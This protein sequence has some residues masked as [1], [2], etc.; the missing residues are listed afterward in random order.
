MLFARNKAYKNILAV[1]FTNKASEEMKTRII[2]DLAEI[3]NNENNS[4]LN[5]II[6][7]LNL[8][9]L[10]VKERAANV[11]K[12]ILH[13]Y[14]FFS[15]STI[16]S[17]FQKIIRNFSREIGLQYNYEVELDTGRVIGVV[18]DNMLE[19][20]EDDIDLKNNIIALVEQNIENSN[21]WDFRNNLKDFLR[22]VI[23]SDFRTYEKKYEEF[24]SDV[25][26]VRIF[27]EEL[28]S[29]EKNFLGIVSN[30]IESIK[31]IISENNLSVADFNGGNSRSIIKRILGTIE[32]INKN[33]FDIENHF[34]DSDNIEKWLTKNNLIKEPLHSLTLR[35]IQK[36]EFLKV[37]ICRHYKN[38]R[39]CSIIK[40]H[41][42]YAALINQTLQYLHIYLNETGKFLI[43][44][45]PAF[46]AEIAN[47]NS[48]SFIYEKIG[49]YYENYLIDEFQDTSKIQ[50]ESFYP[51][52]LESLSSVE[53]DN[54]DII[55]GDV[56]QSIYSWRGGDWKLL[57]K[58]I[59]E[60]FN[61]FVQQIPLNENWR[62]GE[63][64]V[65]FN[66]K[67]FKTASEI[68]KNEINNIT[69]ESYQGV[70]GDLITST[71]YNNIEQSTEKN[72]NSVVN[73]NLYIKDVDKESD[74]KSKSVR[75]MIKQIESLQENG[76]KPGDI[77]ILVRKND[78]GAFVAEEIISY[79]N[80]S[81][82]KRGIIYDVISSEALSVSSNKSVQLIISF[83][84]YLLNE[85][86]R[87]SL[88]ESAYMYY[89]QTR[90][91]FSESFNF[92]KGD[93]IQYFEKE[94]KDLRQNLK[95][96]LLHDIV[97]VVINTFGLNKIS[98]NV[99]FLNSFRD[100][101]HEYEL[102]YPAE[103][104]GFLEYWEE[105]GIKQNLKIPE[106]QNAINII[107]I[108]KA[109]G[110][111]AD[112]VF[113]PFCNWGFYKTSNN[114]IWAKCE[115]VEPFNK[116]PVW[117]V[118]FD[119]KLINSF[120]EEEY[121]LHKFK[122]T[123]ESFNMMYVAF[124]R[125]RKGLYISALD[126]AEGMFNSVEKLL[127]RVF[128]KSEFINDLNFKVV[129]DSDFY[130]LEYEIGSVDNV[131]ATIENV[132]YFDKYP[133]YIPQKQIKVKS[134]FD[135][136]KINIE[137]ESAIH[138]GIVYH[139]IFERIK[140]F[141]DVDLAINDLLLKGNIRSADVAKYKNEIEQIII[142]PYI[143]PWFDNTYNVNNE[144][145]IMTKDG[146]LRRPD[147]IMEIDSEIIIVDYKFGHQENSKYLK[148]AKQYS[149]FLTEM[150]YQNIKSYIWYV[151]SGYLIKVNENG[152][153]FEKIILDR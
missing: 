133:V 47:N 23:D 55:V 120:F 96:K 126:N 11:F 100:I 33:D 13:D 87:L 57:A 111:A 10:L 39:T 141:D 106:K 15:I 24:F 137:S 50:W 43:S 143:Y 107:T 147:R 37:D 60:E 150:G 90:L 125:A 132:K 8:P 92:S 135:R 67:F 6:E 54:V 27:K 110:L 136:D 16:D 31:K 153:S 30:H 151:L 29:I 116:L 25:N 74:F 76:H 62:S 152:E 118:N 142:H 19:Q 128:D 53:E 113:I 83:F 91:T 1:T 95:Q 9:K 127:C 148:Q 134:F 103:I 28:N 85:E 81:E 34:K 26:S 12:E 130:A 82:A 59:Y 145:E 117:P 93:F 4:R 58:T 102:R 71:I 36:V 98:D 22:K 46:L 64:I 94:V 3:I 5:E 52:L 123:V 51:L 77:M 129:D 109:K 138:K 73:I 14:S 88:V 122:Q 17:F 72:I 45:V 79:A 20:S 99:P 49:S 65:N 121:Y 68:L 70:T 131:E 21:R 108:H 35:L 56:K 119:N 78:E 140:C 32:K 75:K 61:D 42:N 124:T 101:V 112:F 2:S 97:D 114:M 69:S 105:T 104:S 63:D 86:D 84:R 48:S 41:F 66:N 89:L 139:K 40:K 38:Y 44:Q 7:S 144:M 80:S 115:N 18:V 146:Y 149:D